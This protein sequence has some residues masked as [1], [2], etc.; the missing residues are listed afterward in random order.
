M[1]SS[2]CTTEGPDGEARYNFSY[3]DQVY[4]GLLAN[5]ARPV[6]ELSFMP[7]SARQRA[8]RRHSFWYQSGRLAAQGLR[9]LG[10]PDCRVRPPPRGAL[11]DRRGRAAGTSRCG[12]SL[13]SISGPGSRS[14]STYF[15]LYDHAARSRQVRGPAAAGRGARRPRRRH[16]WRRSFVTARKTVCRWTSSRRTCTA[17]TLPKTYSAPRRAFPA[18]AWCAARCRKCMT[19]IQSFPLPALPLLWTRVTT[20]PSGPR[21]R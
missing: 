17:M 21:R 18:A 20:R 14:Q 6:V 8:I 9:A 12:T 7:R 11:R 13:T 2:G 4:D 1:T 19:E 5:G 15:T 3:V 10:C 16:G